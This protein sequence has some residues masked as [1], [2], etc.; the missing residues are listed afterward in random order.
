MIN[1]AGDLTYFMQGGYAEGWPQQ[2]ATTRYWDIS[3]DLDYGTE[4]ATSTIVKGNHTIGNLSIYI[5]TNGVADGATVFTMRKTTGGVSSDTTSTVTFAAGETGLKQD[6]VHT[7]DLVSGDSYCVKA[8]AAGTV[9]AISPSYISHTITGSSFIQ[10][11]VY[12]PSHSYSGAINTYVPI[13]GIEMDDTTEANVS[14][15]IKQ[16]VTFSNLRVYCDSNTAAEDAIITFRINGGD[17]N[18]TIT[19]PHGTIGSFEDVTHTDSVITNDVLDWHV[20]K[21]GIGDIKISLIQMKAVGNNSMCIN[22][23]PFGTDISFGTTQYRTVFGNLFAQTAAEA[24]A[25]CPILNE[26]T[27]KNLYVKVT[28]N[29]LDGNTVVTLRKNN[30]DTTL[31]ITISAGDIGNYHNTSDLISFSSTDTIDYQVVSGGSMGAIT[32]RMIAV[33]L[34]PASPAPIPTLTPSSYS[35]INAVIPIILVAMVILLL[36][37]IMA[38]GELDLGY[39]L[40]AV[41]LLYVL[42]AFLPSIQAVVNSIIGS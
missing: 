18:Q 22:S 17:G 34:L 14:Y 21:G 8:V 42:Y 39:I 35:G 4:I 27:A 13:G 10:Q 38:S 41:I 25:A 3:G 23:R 29:T 16:S 5:I 31:S 12:A 30:A 20:V 36:V 2:H 19:I 9:G 7:F 24:P 40:I 15:P 28:A 37:G 33:D 1:A 6:L 32:L 11:V 26:Q